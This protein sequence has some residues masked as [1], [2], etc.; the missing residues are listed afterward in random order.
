MKRKSFFHWIIDVVICGP[1]AMV[2]IYFIYT[3]SFQSGYCFL[4]ACFIVYIVVVTIVLLIAVDFLF[5]TNKK[6]NQ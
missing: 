5:S 1:L 4:K 3:P 6:N 2:L